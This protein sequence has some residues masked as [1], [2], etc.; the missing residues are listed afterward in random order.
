MI[1]LP[2]RLSIYPSTYFLPIDL[3]IYPPI[4]LPTHLSAYLYTHLS[5]YLVATNV[6]F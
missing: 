1:Y 6:E 4:N 3:P 5:I 2:I